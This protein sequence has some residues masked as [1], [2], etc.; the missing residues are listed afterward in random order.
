MVEVG[1]VNGEV[2][3]KFENDD[4]VPIINFPMIPDEAR[5]LVN[6]LGQA[7]K[8]LTTEVVT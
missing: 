5:Q 6:S 7:I 8:F 4:R 3:L 1:T 2:V